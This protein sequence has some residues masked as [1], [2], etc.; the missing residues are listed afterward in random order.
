MVIHETR[1]NIGRAARR[2]GVSKSI[3]SRRLRRL[4]TE[5]GARLLSRTMRSVSPTEAGVEFKARSELILV[6]LEDDCDVVAPRG[7]EIVGLWVLE[8]GEQG[9]RPPP[10]AATPGARS[11]QDT[12]PNRSDRG[13]LRRATLLGFLSDESALMKALRR[14][15][16]KPPETS[17]ARSSYRDRQVDGGQP[18]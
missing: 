6:H 12:G 10:G 16:V 2:L 3:V 8:G 13:P 18:P 17:R 11:G 14:G 5:L 4:D 1:R 7:N 15:F 9:G